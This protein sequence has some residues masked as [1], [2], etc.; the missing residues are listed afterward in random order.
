MLQRLLLAGEAGHAD[1]GAVVSRLQIGD[2]ECAVG[3]RGS[4]QHLRGWTEVRFTEALATEGSRGIDHLTAKR[5]RT[6]RCGSLLRQQTGCEGKAQQQWSGY[7]N[8]HAGG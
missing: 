8:E 4:R 2:L 7:Q 1:R 3:V 5:P 6:S